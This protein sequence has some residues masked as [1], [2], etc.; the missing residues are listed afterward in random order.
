MVEDLFR[1][2]RDEDGIPL[3]T[4]VI[5]EM[6]VP[7]MKSSPPQRQYAPPVV[8]R[9]IGAPISPPQ[10]P[11]EKIDAML[12]TTMASP[13]LTTSPASSV[14]DQLREVIVQRVLARLQPVL[15]QQL[16]DTTS[17]VLDKV[18][19]V[20]RSELQRSLMHS[21]QSVT[22]RTVAQ[23]LSKLSVQRKSGI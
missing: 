5:E 17:E 1:P 19:P 2:R 16:S 4:E 10:E 20:L 22:A 9:S 12:L 8:E 3:L 6:A 13:V 23:E 7:P 21:V 18:L 11:S 15:E 14:E